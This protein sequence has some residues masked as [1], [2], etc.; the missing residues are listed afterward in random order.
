MVVELREKAVLAEAR[1]EETQVYRAKKSQG[2]GEKATQLSKEDHGRGIRTGN[3]KDAA[4]STNGNEYKNIGSGEHKPTSGGSE[5]K[6]T[7]GGEHMQHALRIIRAERRETFQ[8]RLWSSRINGGTVPYSVDAG[9]RLGSTAQE[10]QAKA[11][12][13]EG[14]QTDEVTSSNVSEVLSQDQDY[15]YTVSYEGR[16]EKIE[17]L[18]PLPLYIEP[19]PVAVL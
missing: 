10:S 11:L 6:H 13:S 16:S 2:R 12:N 9:A 14:R 4:W 18:V 7:S 15:V 3:D 1:V 5:E 17:S 8:H 19:L